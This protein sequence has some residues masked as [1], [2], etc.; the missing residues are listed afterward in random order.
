MNFYSNKTILITGGTGSIGSRIAKYL[1]KNHKLKK[2]II[3]SRDEQ[4]HFQMQKDFNHENVRYL[5]GDIR[6]YRRLDMALNGVDFVIHAAAQ[7]H[8][9]I[10][11]Y[12]PQEC[13]K[14]NVNGTQNLIEA[15]LTNKVKKCLLISTDKA[16]NPANIYG[17]S[18]LVAEKIT[19]AGNSLSGKNGTIFGLVRYGNVLGSKGSILPFFSDLNKKGKKIPITHS[20]MTRFWISYDEAIELI[21]SALINSRRGDIFIPILN[22]I[23]ITD[24]VKIIN[25]K[26]KTYTTG[27]K[28]G[29]KI[30]E[31]LIT[32]EESKYAKKFKN[33]YIINHD[34]NKKKDHGFNY[35]SEHKLFDKK[36]PVKSSYTKIIKNFL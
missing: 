35:T 13:I 26:A 12:N 16:V 20:D 30:H 18:K 9:E 7:K 8:V 21:N 15:C 11:E 5:I 10:S 36:N 28:R 6:D 22:S 3:F 33:Y 17:A 27:I 23:K 34:L 19:L 2:I 25:P 32:L 31:E 24:F 1:H 4:K 29:E 14:T